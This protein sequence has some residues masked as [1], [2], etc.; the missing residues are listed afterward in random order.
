MNDQFEFFLK[1]KFTDTR[2][3]AYFGVV[4]LSILSLLFLIFGIAT[5]IFP[6]TLVGI[7]FLTGVYFL[8]RKHKGN[9][10]SSS[11][12]INEIKQ[13]SQNIIWIKPNVT[14]HTV[15]YVF[16]FYKEQDFE[17]LTKDKLKITINCISDKEQEIFLEGI[18][19]CLFE[20]QFGFT[21]EV[22]T[23]YHNDPTNFINSLKA[24]EIYTPIGVFW[25]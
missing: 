24:R 6:I 1:N 9:L 25:K 13:N 2:M 16:T 12:W 5:S 7:V 19:D 8:A 11:F 10:K 15:G 17:L 3:G 4:I 21:H 20:A 22:E 14:F 18:V 23:L